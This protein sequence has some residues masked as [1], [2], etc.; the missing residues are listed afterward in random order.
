MGSEGQEEKNWRVIYHEFEERYKKTEE[1][2]IRWEG[3]GKEYEKLRSFLVDIS[4]T[5]RRPYLVP[6]SEKGFIPGFLVHTNEILV[7][8]GENWF[9]ER[10]SVQAIDIVDRRLEYVNNCLKTLDKKKKDLKSYLDHVIKTNEGKIYNEEGLPIVEIR[11]E[12]N[13][14]GSIANSEVLENL[15]ENWLKEASE[16]LM[17]K[18]NISPETS[19]D[20]EVFD[21]KKDSKE[22]STN[23]GMPLTK[24]DM[25]EDYFMTDAEKLDD[26]ERI[27][28]IMNE[29]ESNGDENEYSCD[30]N[31]SDATE[32]KYGRTCGF[33]SPVCLDNTSSKTF[34]S[35]KKVSFSD[36]IVSLPDDNSHLEDVDFSKKENIKSD[37]IIK[38][39]IERPSIQSTEHVLDNF[40]SSFHRREIATEYYRLKQKFQAQNQFSDNHS[41][42]T[43]ITEK[44]SSK[45][46]SRFK[47][48]IMDKK[49]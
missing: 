39:V 20:C 41:Q 11:E 23:I 47:A 10:S 48:A 22:I 34:K 18:L 24:C 1:D 37:F 13:E 29:L 44:N 8:Y 32:D 25:D 14:D 6:F 9:V 28:D 30:S 45:K 17:K 19:K 7:L 21:A 5:T 40:T 15:G 12:L 3:Y 2:F 31:D 42:Q 38:D 36:H 26:M 4:K 43:Y 27:I 16:E 49:N 35:T 46:I 33:I